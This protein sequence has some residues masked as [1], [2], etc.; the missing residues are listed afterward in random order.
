MRPTDSPI[1]NQ[2]NANFKIQQ[3]ED[4]D[5]YFEFSTLTGAVPSGKSITITVLISHL[6]S[7]IPGTALTID[8]SLRLR[9]HQL[10]P[11]CNL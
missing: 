9:I 11:D 2:V 5:P 3:P 8:T 7:H 10:Q 6:V 1:L 4:T